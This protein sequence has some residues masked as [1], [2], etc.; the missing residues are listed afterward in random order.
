M[1]FILCCIVA[2]LPTPLTPLQILATNIITDA[3]P[4]LALSAMPAENDV[5]STPPRN[6]MDFVITGNLRW[7]TFWHAISLVVILPVVYVITLYWS[8]GS[9]LQNDIIGLID[10][11]GDPGLPVTERGS[12]CRVYSSD[13]PGW[14]RTFDPDC[15][16]EAIR[17]G[18]TAVFLL[19]ALA[20]NCRPYTVRWLYYPFWHSLFSNI[21]LL[22]A[23]ALSLACL[24]VIMFVEPVQDLFGTDNLPWYDWLLVLGCVAITVIVDEV[25]KKV[26]YKS[27]RKDDDD[28]DDEDKD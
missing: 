15:E 21:P 26:L 19:L 13:P 24:F 22:C 1:A 27:R 10:E 9:I 4:A 3:L 11:E 17:R 12:G 16:K 28:E 6:R 8:S 7:L 20:E 2:G 23:T 5:M 14:S 25:V 18:R